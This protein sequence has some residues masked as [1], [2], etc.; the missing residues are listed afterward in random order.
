MI[1][2]GR[3]V[4]EVVGVGGCKAC[5]V[6]TVVLCSEGGERGRWQYPSG[7]IALSDYGL[8]NHYPACACCLCMC[9]YE[10]RAKT[11]EDKLVSLTAQVTQ[12]QVS[13]SVMDLC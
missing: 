1:W 5:G 8:S 11:L 3:L 13:A 10:K 9:R 7:C 2:A 12:L 6:V 4:G